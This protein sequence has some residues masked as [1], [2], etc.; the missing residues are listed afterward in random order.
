VRKG[1]I[2]LV[3]LNKYEVR[4]RSIASMLQKKLGPGIGT[5][6]KGLPR[7]HEFMSALHTRRSLENTFI[8]GSSD[9]PFGLLRIQFGSFLAK[10]CLVRGVFQNG[11]C[12]AYGA[13]HEIGQSAFVFL[14]WRTSMTSS[15][16]M[17]Y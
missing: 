4:L 7:L 5:L 11:V 6:L 10:V 1:E 12:P 2:C 3:S 9:R 17:L 13:R 16:R 8:H 14:I 15:Y